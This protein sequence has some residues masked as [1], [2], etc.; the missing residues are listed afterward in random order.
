ML[1][2]NYAE[3]TSIVSNIRKYACSLLLNTILILD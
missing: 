3:E 2:K 1:L